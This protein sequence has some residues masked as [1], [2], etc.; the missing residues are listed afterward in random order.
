M[1]AA[2]FPSGRPNW[3]PL[4][5]RLGLAL[6]FLFFGQEKLFNP[7]LWVIYVTPSMSRVLENTGLSLLQFY[8]W[9]GALELVL[10]VQLIL[11]WSLRGAAVLIALELAGIVAVVGLDHT[12]VRDLG[13]LLGLAVPLA[14]QNPDHW[15]LDR[16]WRHHAA[17]AY[18]HL[19]LPTNR[20]V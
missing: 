7:E 3:M 20:E 18:T 5:A 2:P 8:H 10:A 16:V 6:V 19:T 14:F 15:S 11:G 17:V 9:L 12:G 4:C 1:T 13:L